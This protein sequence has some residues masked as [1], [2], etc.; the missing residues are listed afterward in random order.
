M[1]LRFRLRQAAWLLALLSIGCGAAPPMSAEAPS[2]ARADYESAGAPMAQPSMAAEAPGMPMPSPAQTAM[3]G[4][5]AAPAGAKTPGE[6]PSSTA[7]DNPQLLIIYTASLELVVETDAFVGVLDAIHDTAESLGGYLAWR[8]DNSIEVRIPSARFREG[9]RSIEKNADV[10]HRSIT[11][12]DVSEQFHDLDVRLTN[13]KATRKRLEE[14]LAKSGTMADMLNVERELERVAAE[15]DR[16]EGR[17]RFLKSRAAFSTVTVTLTPRAQVAPPPPPPP[18]PAPP[19]PR[20]LRV[21]VPWLG[22]VGLDQ[23]LE[24]Q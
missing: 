18:P 17:L 4:P 5:P 12:E 15:I 10:V 6:A 22:D 8:K 23:L 24:L 7:P 11:A 9:L 14:F 1:V 20:E 19:P 2:Y 16:I 13:L 3:S 21:P